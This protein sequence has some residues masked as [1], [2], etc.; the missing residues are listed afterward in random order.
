M[1]RQSV[2]IVLV[3]LCTC[4]GVLTKRP[5]IVFILT[6]DQDVTM[7]GETPMANTLNMIGKKGM[8]FQNMFTSS[9]LC[10]PSRSSIL[11]GNYVHNHRAINNSIDGNCSSKAWQQGPEQNTFATHLKNIGYKTFFAGKYLNQYGDKAVGG[12]AHIP[13]GWDEWHGL[14]HNSVYYNYTLSVNG[15]AEV[16]GDDYAKDYLTDIINNR[17]HEF[18]A[19]QNGIFP[20]FA[21]VSTPACHSPFDSAP[22]YMDEFADKKAPRDPSFNKAGMDKHWLIRHAPYPL[23][24]ASLT[25][26]VDTFRKRWRT[27]LS[28][29][30]MVKNIVTTLDEIKLL[31][32]TFIIFASDNGFHLG[33]FSLP[34]DKRQ[35]YDFDI[36]VPLMIRGPGIPANS[37]NTDPVMNIDIMPTIIALAGEQAPSN[38]DGMSL[39][40]L[41]IPKTNTTIKWRNGALIE[42]DGEYAPG[43]SLDCKNT[44]YLYNCA[45]DCVCEDG[46][47]NTYSCRRVLTKTD[48]TMYCE[49]SDDENFQEF[50][51]FT[52]DPHQLTNTIKKMT[53]EF[54]AE[55]NKE[56]VK[57]SLCKG[58]SCR[59]VHPP[60][61]EDRDENSVIKDQSSNSAKSVKQ[62]GILESNSVVSL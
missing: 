1:D 46:F 25:Y 43:G 59:Q 23:S 38:V 61:E 10:C 60:H 49:F 15:K 47:N 57:L 28:V 31:D 52:S 7:G 22:Q 20:F 30:D 50:Y 32:E 4:L 41:L 26:I 29:D 24:N 27:L 13:P 54:L 11:T 40:P 39:V 55:Q 2:G 42:H 48:N 45:P 33:Q 37:K 51:N 35:L 19:K 6:D 16:H 53:P 17:S 56:L 58:A 9:P 36:R 3:L 14:V 34:N 44:D 8:T 21:M 62:N 5:N 12:V 18:L